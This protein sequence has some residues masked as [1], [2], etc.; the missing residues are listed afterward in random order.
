MSNAINRIIKES[1]EISKMYSSFLNSQEKKH[2]NNMKEIDKKRNLRNRIKS[3]HS[4]K[5]NELL[6]CGETLALAVTTTGFAS[7]MNVNIDDLMKNDRKLIDVG[8]Q[9]NVDGYI[10]KLLKENLSVSIEAKMIETKEFMNKIFNY[11][12]IKKEIRIENKEY[13]SSNLKQKLSI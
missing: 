9:G 5:T 3:N 2:N 13:K 11:E 7:Q 12:K 8:K 10:K 6:A 1:N 4:L